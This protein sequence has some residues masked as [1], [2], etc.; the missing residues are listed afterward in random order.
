MEGGDHDHHYCIAEFTNTLLSSTDVTVQ[1]NN[2]HWR[3]SAGQDQF[4]SDKERSSSLS[5]PKRQPTDRAGVGIVFG[6]IEVAFLSRLIV[7]EEE[8]FPNQP[9]WRISTL[10]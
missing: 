6:V 4:V 5:S 3:C 2:K 7:Y 9:P 1:T 10:T 8:I